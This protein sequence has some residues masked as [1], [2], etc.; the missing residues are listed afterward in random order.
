VPS[1]F[2]LHFHGVNAAGVA[3]IIRSQQEGEP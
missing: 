3:A 1:V 2:H